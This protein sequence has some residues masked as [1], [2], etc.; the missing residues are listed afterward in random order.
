MAS[1][2]QRFRSSLLQTTPKPRDKG[3]PAVLPPIHEKNENN[4]SIPPGG[5]GGEGGS[6]GAGAGGLDGGSIS[7]DSKQTGDPSLSLHNVPSSPQQQQQQ[8]AARKGGFLGGGKDVIRAGFFGSEDL[9]ALVM[10]GN[11]ATGSSQSMFGIV[12]GV[13]V[14]GGLE[15]VGGGGSGSVGGE[16]ESKPSLSRWQKAAKA[17]MNSSG[18]GGGGGELKG[19]GKGGMSSLGG[20]GTA[21]TIGTPRALMKDKHHRN[22]HHQHNHPNPS[23]NPS[24]RH[25]L[26]GNNSVSNLSG[27]S[28]FAGNKTPKRGASMF[29]KKGTFYFLPS[30]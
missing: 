19:K 17:A 6:A 9:T 25:L 28:W 1:F 12:M 26:S 5:G 24:Q 4:Q 3:H 13:G 8:K 20:G 2:A 21:W 11:R 15:G 27:G 10:A 30:T 29:G 7:L 22:L 18:S 16:E 23:H 14:D